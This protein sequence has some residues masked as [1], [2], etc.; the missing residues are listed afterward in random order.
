MPLV[1]PDT[2]LN[3]KPPTTETLASTQVTVAEGEEGDDTA[4]DAQSVQHLAGNHSD[5][6]PEVITGLGEVSPLSYP[7]RNPSVSMPGLPHTPSHSITVSIPPESVKNTQNTVLNANGGRVPPGLMLNGAATPS[8]KMFMPGGEVVSPPRLKDFPTVLSHINALENT[9]DWADC[10]IQVLLPN[11]TGPAWIRPGHSIILLRS[12]RLRNMLY[13]QRAQQYF[14]YLVTLF[15]ARA[16]DPNAF[17]A[18]LRFLYTDTILSAERLLPPHSSMD[19]HSKVRALDYVLSYMAAGLELGID[20]VVTRAFEL[21]GRLIDWDVVEIIVKEAVTL[22]TA[23]AAIPNSPPESRT[24]AASLLQYV[25][26]LFIFQLDIPQFQL[27]NEATPSYMTSRLSPFDVGRAAINPALATMVFGSMPASATD[28]PASSSE[29]STEV[30]SSPTSI[31]SAILLN[32][33]YEDL[34]VLARGLEKVYGAEGIRII[35]DAVA[36]RERRRLHVFENKSFS[37]KQRSANQHIWDV[38]GWREHVTDN[39]LQRDRVGFI[40]SNN[41]KRGTFI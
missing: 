6:A 20:P 3:S 31:A 40:L 36:E 9:H 37:N 22:R 41:N 5:T 29:I 19:R 12:P 2:V 16:I 33:G 17:D 32:L 39:H 1:E 25:F 30:A 8:R 18:A 10:E 11:A 26:N 34:C 38:I 23:A 14:F 27:D 4:K 13:A 28:S 35:S 21:L 15:P 7:S 24:A